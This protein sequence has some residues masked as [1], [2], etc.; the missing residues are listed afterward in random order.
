MSG[1][2]SDR[3]ENRSSVD[4]AVD[5]VIRA[6]AHAPA[7]PPP[8]EPESGTRWGEKG[9]YIVER[10]LG[11]GGMGTVYLATDSLLGRRVA[12]KVLD[13]GESHEDEARHARLLRE[14]RLAAVLEHERV[15]RVYDVADHD[16][17]T[18][19]AMEYVRGA[20]LRTWMS[21]PRSATDRL[22][23]LVQVA[24]GLSFLHANGIVHRDLK[25]ENVMLPNAGGAKLL[26]FG[27]ASQVAQTA[28]SRTSAL[29]PWD[30]EG[31]NSAFRGTP[32]YMAPEQYSGERA[33]ERA[34]VFALGV[35]VYELVTGSRPFQG[36]TIGALRL[37]VSRGP[38]AMSD[39][40]W[41]G[42]PRSL[43]EVTRRMLERDP[44]ARLPSGTPA[45]EALRSVASVR[46][47]E[48]HHDSNEGDPELAHLASKVE[49]FWLD[50]VL[51]RSELA[52]I[53]PQRRT[54][55]FSFVTGDWEKHYRAMHD[56]R[57]PIVET[58]ALTTE[59]FE[60]AGRVLLIVGDP[61]CG[62]T[63][64][65]LLIARHLL[66]KEHE[67]S[68]PVPVVFNLSTWRK[69]VSA[70]TWFVNE[71]GAIYQ[72]PRTAAERWLRSNRLAPLLDGLDEVPGDARADCV[73]AMNA[74]IA[75]SR[76][77]A[78]VI[79]ARVEA[80]RTLSVRPALNAALSAPPAD[81][82]ADRVVRLHAAD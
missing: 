4:D 71:L 30:A 19:V 58:P 76:P 8:S 33:D 72:V 54:L 15:A 61:G 20:T 6:I 17:S 78:V 56:A 10:R 38:P 64:N 49:R 32:G 51:A 26:D 11:R 47:A 66:Q 2:R 40:A 43:R 9:R 65:L 77:P 53:L 7:R 36:A 70:A 31:S 75:S 24:E 46:S 34:D 42:F 81:Q 5:E 67:P 73:A 12:L 35:M 14:A 80:C 45:L 59:I 39:A 79:T 50:N 68:A 21:E 63:L 57:D 48:G 27:L 60:D 55:D 23:V 13:A 22:A 3:P 82:P 69:G 25:P 74:F 1:T 18:F 16:G 52:G 37:A 28:V 44:D 41:E 62:K 29:P